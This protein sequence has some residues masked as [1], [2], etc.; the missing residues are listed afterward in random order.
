MGKAEK[1]RLFTKLLKN[2]W[3][4]E[5][6][7]ESAV[8]LRRAADI[9]FAAHAASRAE[10]GEPVSVADLEMDTPATLL[11]GYSMENAVKSVL[12]KE[13]GVTREN[14]KQVKGWQ[15]HDLVELASRVENLKKSERRLLATL[16]AFVNWAG[17]YPVAF[18]LEQK[19]NKGF[20]LAEQYAHNE[21]DV[22]EDMPPSVF[23]SGSR[24]I[25][26]KLLD[27]LIARGRLKTQVGADGIL[28]PEV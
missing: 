5:H 23:D 2:S 16:T 17:K 6:W 4:A 21:I 22:C 12:I 19:G 26:D 3:K 27:K 25:A 10:D 20:I 24:R 9:L 13:E 11:Y 14:C 1:H 8:N 15:G 18:E 28:R 7:A